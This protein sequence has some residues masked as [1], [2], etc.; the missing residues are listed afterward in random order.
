MEVG[1]AESRKSVSW[2]SLALSFF[3][4]ILFII[5]VHGNNL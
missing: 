1:I 2:F 5:I 4:S 3:D